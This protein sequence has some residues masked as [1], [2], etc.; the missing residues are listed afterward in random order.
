LNQLGACVDY[1]GLCVNGEIDNFYISQINGL[2]LMID[3]RLSITEAI[4]RQ[5][6]V[7][8]PHCN[9]SEK[10]VAC[11]NPFFF[12]KQ[13]F[14]FIFPSSIAIRYLIPKFNTF[15]RKNNSTYLPMSNIHEGP[16]W[17]YSSWIYNYLCN[18]CIS[19]LKWVW[20]SFMA[21]CTQYNIMW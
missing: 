11:S 19:P 4:L 2:C 17:L 10:E 3:T 18:Q 21:R 6:F 14:F 7:K 12:Q 20:T 8:L 13:L 1:L 9:L 5:L 15:K 16:S